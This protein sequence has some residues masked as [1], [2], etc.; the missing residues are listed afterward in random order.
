[1]KHARLLTV[2]LLLF[3]LAAVFTVCVA[4]E[5][6][7]MYYYVDGTNGSDDFNGTSPSTAVKTFSEACRYAAKSKYERVAIVFVGEYALKSGVTKGIAHDNHF[8][9]TTNDGITDYGAKGAKIVFGKSCRFNITGPTAFENISFDFTSSITFVGNYHETT[10]GE[11]V[12]FN[13]LTEEGKG[14]YVYGGYRQPLDTVT[15]IDKDAHLT[16][17][18]GNYYLIVGGSKDLGT[19]ED[20]KKSGHIKFQNTNYL[21]INGGTFDIVYGGTHTAHAALNVDVTVNGGKI[22]RLNAAGD[23]TRRAY[24]DGKVTLNGGEIGEFIFNNIIGAGMVAFNGTKIEKASLVYASTEIEEYAAKENKK[25]VASYDG[26]FYT[27]E[28]VAMLTE[29]Y[30]SVVNATYIY[31]KENGRGSGASKEDAASFADAFA[32]AVEKGAVVKIVNSITVDSFTEPTHKSKV[33]ISGEDN[34]SKLNLSGSYTLGG[35]TEISGITL[36]GN[37]NVNAENGTFIVAADAKT[38]LSGGVFSMSAD[39]NSSLNI[40][41]SATLHAGT[42]GTITNVKTLIVDGATVNSVILSG[43]NDATVSI[44]SGEIK[45]LVFRNMQGETTLQYIGGKISATAVE[46]DNKSGAFVAGSGITAVG[47]EAMRTQLAVGFAAAG[48]D[49]HQQGDEQQ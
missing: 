48:A 34:N 28:E 29:G 11:N 25:K 27:A 24:G 26:N 20:G 30:D 43:T 22:N 10:F 32:K 14:V 41:G 12:Q 44:N 42:F 6:Y 47:A 15:P 4:A 33:V 45:N 46:G 18:S 3:A 2:L 49:G 38:S 7:E 1:M 16:I 5:E 40:S 19:N 17:N 39:N 8:T 9:L 31:A 35:E 23:A 21:T 36:T 37:A 13:K